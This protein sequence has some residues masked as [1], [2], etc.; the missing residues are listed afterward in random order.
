MS[1]VGGDEFLVDVFGSG[2]LCGSAFVGCGK[3]CSRVLNGSRLM[4][5]FWN[6]TAYGHLPLAV[7]FCDEYDQWAAMRLNGPAP[8]KQYCAYGSNV[9]VVSSWVMWIGFFACFVPEVLLV[10]ADNVVAVDD[11]VRTDRLVVVEVTVPWEDAIDVLRRR[12]RASSCIGG[13]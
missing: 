7:V 1:S 12:V 5:Y 2:P 9:V 10:P 11:R 4:T 6:K 3:C 13:C 8:Q